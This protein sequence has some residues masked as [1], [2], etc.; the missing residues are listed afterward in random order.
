MMRLYFEVVAEL[1]GLKKEGLVEEDPVFPR[2]P[3]IERFQRDLKK[4]GVAYR[5]SAGRVADF[6]AL[7]KTFGTNMAQAGVPSRVAMALMRH[8]DRRLT[9][10]IYTDENPIGTW[11]AIQALPDYTAQ[12]SQG[13]S[14]ISV[15][16]GQVA[17]LAGT[18][19]PSWET[20]NP[21]ANTGECHFLTLPVT[22]G[23]DNENGGSGGART[24]NLCRDRAAL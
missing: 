19:T 7:R 15:A 2:F 22:V 4:A 6:H 16:G 12:P 9:D 14:Q 10:K 13:A 11:S 3:R 18:G 17:A 23:Q 1:R 8:S 21:L 5:D 20:K 24:R